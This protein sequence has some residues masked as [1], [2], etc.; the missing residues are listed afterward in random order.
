MAQQAS[1]LITQASPDFRE[2]LAN[3]ICDTSEQADIT[4]KTITQLSEACLNLQVFY[5]RCKAQFGGTTRCLDSLLKNCPHIQRLEFLLSDDDNLHGGKDSLELLVHN[6]NWLT[7]LTYF[8]LGRY[9]AYS[10]EGWEEW[11]RKTTRGR[12][13]LHL[14]IGDSWSGT[15]TVWERGEQQGE[16]PGN[17]KDWPPMSRLSMNAMG[18]NGGRGS[19]SRQRGGG[20]GTPSNSNSINI[21]INDLMPKASPTSDPNSSA[22]P[23]PSQRGLLSRDFPDGQEGMTMLGRMRRGGGDGGGGQV[24]EQTKAEYH[25]Y[26]WRKK[27]LV[28]IGGED[29]TSVIAK[30]A[31]DADLSGADM[32]RF[33]AT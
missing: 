4:E 13:N 24:S 30:I 29:P 31:L 11:F 15:T 27:I 10:R 19:S 1:H 12:H 3:I 5:I 16:R 21:N 9:F 20:G 32:T 14:E 18:S 7:H 33:F 23:P 17:W 8:K 22:G 25:D 2:N 28:E 6:S 26:E